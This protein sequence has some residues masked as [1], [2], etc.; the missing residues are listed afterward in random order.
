MQSEVTGSGETCQVV[1]ATNRARRMNRLRR[2]FV[3]MHVTEHLQL[4]HP[5][6]HTDAIGITEGGTSR[7]QLSR[8]YC[9]Q[10]ILGSI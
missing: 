10:R 5:V 8:F 1:I 3:F 4:F 6:Y 9:C 7:G 2:A